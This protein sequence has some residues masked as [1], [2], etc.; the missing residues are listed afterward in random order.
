VFQEAGTVD[1]LAFNVQLMRQG[2][3]S[4]FTKARDYAT[5]LGLSMVYDAAVFVLKHMR[6][7]DNHKDAPPEQLAF[8]VGPPPLALR[9]RS[10]PPVISPMFNVFTVDVEDYFHPT[11]VAHADPTQWPT[12]PSRIHIGVDFLLEALAEH[13]SRGTFFILGWVADHHPEIVR[14]VAAAGHEI[15]CH[16]YQHRLVYDLTPAQFKEDTRRAVRVIED[17]CGISPRVYRAPSYSIVDKSFWA[18]DVLVECGFTHD[19]SIYPIIHDRYGV[20]GFSRHAKVVTTQS[21]PI[22]EVPIAAAPL[23]GVRVAPVGGGA[24]LRL[25]PYR[26]TA[27]GIRRINQVDGQPACIYVHPWEM[28]PH[29]PRLAK[30]FVSR[31]R[32]YSGLAAM[33]GKVLKLLSEFHFSTLSEIHPAPAAPPALDTAPVRQHPVGA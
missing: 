31:L 23:S 29:Q 7:A 32:T 14:K 21:G 30:G 28:D 27:A 15:G 33:S 5:L 11:E 24:Y 4:M 6:P 17:A 20:P 9:R 3:A 2:E 18:L 13:D 22:V 8:S 26:Y 16:S 25:F 1:S 19:S 10:Q 12:F